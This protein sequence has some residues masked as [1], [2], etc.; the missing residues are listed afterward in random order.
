MGPRY[1]H[2]DT[3]GHYRIK[4]RRDTKDKLQV[5]AKGYEPAAIAVDSEK[6]RLPQVNVALNPTAKRVAAPAKQAAAP[7]NAAAT[8]KAAV[9]VKGAPAPTR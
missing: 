2:V 8:T 9:P 3:A 7:V 5:V 1:T 4:V 6:T